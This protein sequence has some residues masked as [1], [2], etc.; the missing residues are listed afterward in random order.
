[1]LLNCSD[2]WTATPER[3][4]KNLSDICVKIGTY[5]EINKSQ[6]GTQHNSYWCPGAKAPGH[7]YP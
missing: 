7:Q 4:W 3:D 2:T 6:V 1:M 5:E